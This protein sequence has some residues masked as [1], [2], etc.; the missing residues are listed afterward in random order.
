LLKLLIIANESEQ[1]R[2]LS[3]ELAQRG[4]SC[5]VAPYSGRTIEQIALQSPDVVLVDMDSSLAG[6]EIRDLSQSIKQEKH[7]PVIALI[8]GR[9]L[10]ASIP[11]SA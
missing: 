2:E 8:P 3:S 9:S 4:F 10:I 6:S 7:I 1:V 5:L 11:V